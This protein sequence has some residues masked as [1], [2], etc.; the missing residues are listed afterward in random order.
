MAVA[1]QVT[2]TAGRVCRQIRLSQLFSLVTL[3]Q[4]HSS[5]VRSCMFVTKPSETPEPRG[6]SMLGEARTSTEL[7]C[8][9]QLRVVRGA[10]KREP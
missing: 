2:L 4:A 8:F 1:R 3:K 5:V 9:M 7:R 10:S 6:S